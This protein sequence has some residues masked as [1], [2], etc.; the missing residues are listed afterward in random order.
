MMSA[1]Q[2]VGST[3]VMDGLSVL[4]DESDRSQMERMEDLKLSL[5]SP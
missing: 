4:L 1:H 2:M 3:G 5:C